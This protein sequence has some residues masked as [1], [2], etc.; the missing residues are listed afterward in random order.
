MTTTVV[1]LYEDLATAQHAA[2]DLVDSGF[3]R[4][5]I[6]IAASD[7]KGE[8]QQ[9]VGSGQ[10]PSDQ[11]SADS[12]ATNAGIGAL[13]GGVGG[14]LVGLGTLL[15]P[16]V[17]PIIAAGPLFTALTSVGVGAGVGAVAGGLVGALVNMGVPEEEAG[18]YAEGVRRGGA[19]MTVQAT[20]EWINQV[21]TIMERYDPI[22]IEQRASQWRQEGWSGFD[23]NAAAYTAT[24][25]SQ[26]QATSRGSSK[27]DDYELYNARFQ[28]HYQNN[29]ANSSYTYDNFAS[30]YRYGLEL[31][32]Y[33]YY[34][35]H[36]GWAEVEPEAHRAWEEKNPGTWD[37]F[38]DAIRH[39][40][41]QVMETL[42]LGEEERAYSK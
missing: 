4:Q 2:Q 24:T 8:Y 37:H 41:D 18:F 17:G 16:G 15:I 36:R 10:Q 7:A 40:W 13:V 33:D 20:D 31:A 6:S 27:P 42:G 5:D 12:V 21:R 1:A 35:S 30:A 29:Y 25:T 3:N 11:T 14:L 34:G 28:E 26:A 9:Y 38:K 23:A 19:L 32:N 22:D 39:G